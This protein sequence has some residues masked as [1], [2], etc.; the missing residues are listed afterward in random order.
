MPTQTIIFAG[1]LKVL[2]YVRY[3]KKCERKVPKH[4]DVPPKLSTLPF[5]VEYIRHGK[6][7]VCVIIKVLWKLASSTCAGAFALCFMRNGL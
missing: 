1:L 5:D 3:A 2:C 4:V 6:Y 7:E